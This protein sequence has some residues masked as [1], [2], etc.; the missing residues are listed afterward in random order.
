[1]RRTEKTQRL[2]GGRDLGFNDHSFYLANS[3]RCSKEVRDAGVTDAPHSACVAGR[4]CLLVEVAVGGAGTWLWSSFFSSSPDVASSLPDILLSIM[5][6]PL[7]ARVCVAQ[8]IPNPLD[9]LWQTRGPRFSH[10]LNQDLK[11]GSTVASA[12]TRKE[13]KR[14]WLAINFHGYKGLWHTS[15]NFCPSFTWSLKESKCPVSETGPVLLQVWRAGQNLGWWEH[16][17]RSP[18]WLDRKA[19]MHSWVF[20]DSSWFYIFKS[21][22]YFSFEPLWL[23]VF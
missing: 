13:N 6:H 23:H 8:V 20:P 3:S 22:T 12:P 16:I 18:L 19:F 10:V 1:M 2:R 14:I 15:C 17:K 4:R 21:H 5:P 11:S 7:R 9:L